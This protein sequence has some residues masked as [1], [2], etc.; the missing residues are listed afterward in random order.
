MKCLILDVFY[1]K[2][3]AEAEY[4]D[5]IPQDKMDGFVL[6]YTITLKIAEV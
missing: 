5:R 2:A 6:Q 1:K 4:S 3:S